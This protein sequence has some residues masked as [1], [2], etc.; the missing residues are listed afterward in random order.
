MLTKKSV[1]LNFFVFYIAWWAM[2]ISSWKNN[3]VIGWSVFALAMAIH[4]FRVS[5]NKK[6]DVKEVVIIAVL[7]I[8]LDTILAKTGILTFN[9]SFSS[10]IPPF[11][12]MG[13]WFLFATTISYTFI[14]LRN[15]IPAQI[16]VGGFFAPVSYIT[17]AKFGLLS[18]YHP[19][20]T[21]YAIHGACW[22]VF[23]PLCFYISKKLKGF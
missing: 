1:I 13:I 11:W 6:K 9:N 15:K 23:F 14:L 7:G 17:G 2:L 21:Y 20:P 16:I 3:P 5:I 4:F 18:L 19:F 8:L 22:L 12:L 10:T